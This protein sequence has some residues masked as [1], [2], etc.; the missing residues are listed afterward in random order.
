VDASAT[1]DGFCAEV[2]R[3]PRSITRSIHVRV[4]Y[5]EPGATRDAITQATEAG[6]RHVVLSLPAAYP[7]NAAN[8]V[9]D[10]LIAR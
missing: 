5:N 1:L 4:S 2:G 8:W 10:E 7:A 6:F 3:D 9:A